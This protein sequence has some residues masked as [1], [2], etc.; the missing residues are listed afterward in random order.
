MPPIKTGA[1]TISPHA[2]TGSSSKILDPTLFLLRG[3]PL[4]ATMGMKPASEVTARDAEGPPVPGAV[5]VGLQ[6]D[7]RVPGEAVVLFH[8]F[9]D[10]PQPRGLPLS[11]TMGM[12]PASEVT[13]RE[14][15]RQAPGP[16]HPHSLL[17]EQVHLLRL[18]LPAPGRGQDGPLCLRT[19][20]PAEFA[21]LSY[22]EKLPL[23]SEICSQ[24]I[25][26]RI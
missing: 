14:K 21:L 3:L 26:F 9:E 17:Q 13:A 1:T 12:K 4:S 18:L 6:G 5:R 7:L 20:R 11:A 8:G 10:L 2:L 15:A 16:L 23:F 19:F 24:R 22:K 25:N